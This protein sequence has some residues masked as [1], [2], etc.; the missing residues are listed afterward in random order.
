MKN[1]SKKRLRIAYT[2]VVLDLFHY[3]HLQSILFAESISDLNI[4]GIFTDEV[5]EE[6]RIKPITNL[7]E[8]KAIADNLKCIDRVMVQY[9][10]D[11]TEN[12]KKIYEE[13]PDAEIIL[14]HGDDLKFVHGSEY[15]KKIKGRL[16]THPYYDKLSTFKI[17]N[18]LIENKDKFKDIKKFSSYIINQGESDT[19]D[20]RGNKF[21]ISSKADTLKAL[22]PLLKKSKIETLYSFTFSEW[23]N[24]KDDILF[25]TKDIF[26]NNKIVVR[27]SATC[28]DTAEK[29][30]AGQFESVLNVNSSSRKEIEEAI[31]PVLSSYE[32]L[33]AESSF[34]QVLIQKQSKDIIMS[35]VLFTRTLEK[36]APYYV[37][38]Y[39]ESGSTDSVTAG[40]EN[41]TI[42]ISHF[43]QKIPDKMEPLLSS[44]Q[45]IETLIPQMPLDIEFAINKNKE[46]IIFQ[47]RP[48]AANITKGIDD[49]AIKERIINLQEKFKNFNMKQEHL[50]GEKT[51]FADMPDWNP[52]EIIGDNPN[53]LD[54]SLYDYIITNAA[55][56]KARTS[57]GYYDVNPAKLVELF[58]NKPYVNVKN[59]FNSLTPASISPKLREKLITF[60][61]CKLKNNPHLQDK[62]EF[63]VLYTC[64]D[65]NFSN[66]SQ[67]LITADFTQ[68]EIKELQISLTE[69][70]NNLVSDGLKNIE[71]DL[72][73]VFSMQQNRDLIKSKT[74]GEDLTPQELLSHA[75]E[76]LVDCQFKGTVQFSR[77]AR[78]GFIAK[79]LLKSLV[80]HN[81]LTT[82]KYNNL[83]NSISTVATQISEDF[84]KFCSN[85]IT[86]KE[87]LAKYSHLRPGTYDITSLRYD[88]NPNLLNT[89]GNEFE[90]VEKPKFIL[91]EDLAIKITKTFQENELLFD[92]PH[93]IQ[94]VKKATEARELAKFEFTKNL[95]D[96]LELITE[97]G[98][99]MGFTRKELAH[100]DINHILQ[101]KNEIDVNII[102][103]LWKKQIIYRE[104]ERKVQ[105]K[106]QF[107]SVILNL[108]DFEIIKQYSAR[109]NFITDKM[110]QTNVINITSNSNII[111]NV[112]GKIVILENGDPGYDWIFTRN[113]AGLVTKYGGVASH[114]SIRCAEFG[115]PAAI[116]CGET[117]FSK[118]QNAKAF[119]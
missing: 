59:T 64:Y 111:P 43:S 81:I 75:K 18:K 74:E 31:I 77:L 112:E 54:Y 103:E 55:W 32:E 110:I 68:S 42:M 114:M 93:F 25:K 12:L 116:G 76:L 20:K 23:K 106:L 90:P 66:R 29:S 73:T 95:S 9:K 65:L 5:V 46:I 67:E 99:K 118:I 34:N 28:E 21:I 1:D 102:T 10:R 92:A 19:E 50:S 105:E 84:R 53:Y 63:E 35:G 40:K 44:I 56:H 27:S 57:Q 115:I 109:P 47:V 119:S 8:R 89:I 14:V 38:N 88:S 70:T 107:P 7:H 61:M 86:K 60:Y 91:T 96:A 108:Q 113:P 117:I 24:S 94:F 26:T 49:N 36:N 22:Q 52:A 2:G 85:K 41:K 33:G 17:I 13:F 87:F 98:E 16:E 48:L 83:F 80:H 69:L 104:Q 79:I 4:C 15:V 72:Q 30:M 82:E 58:G 71:S 100:L 78:L 97:A 6:Y 37:I 39:D 62:V 45:E 3:G 101:V 11:P 51:F